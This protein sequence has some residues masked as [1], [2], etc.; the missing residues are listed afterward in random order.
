[1]T[2][3]KREQL[4][5]ELTN[6]F[7][8]GI[9]EWALDMY[10]DMYEEELEEIL[11]VDKVPFKSN[12]HYDSYIKDIKNDDYYKELLID[13]RSGANLTDKQVKTAK[14]VDKVLNR[15]NKDPEYVGKDISKAYIKDA[16]VDNNRR[17]RRISTDELSAFKN[18]DAQ[19]AIDIAEEDE[20]VAPVI[21]E[22]YKVGTGNY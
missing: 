16:R 18:I 22:D 20:E 11:E 19:D 2:E 10:K 4:I 5:E 12:H 8:G 13:Y 6:K 21:P 3:T 14:L 15:T 1:M 7:E 9:P 17:F